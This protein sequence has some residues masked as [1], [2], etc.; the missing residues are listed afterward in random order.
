MG[1][2]S[3]YI[4]HHISVTGKFAQLTDGHKTTQ[5]RSSLMLLQ[6]Y[7]DPGEAFSCRTVTRDETWVFH[8]N[9]ESKVKLMTWMHL[10]SPGKKYTTVQSPEKVTATVFCNVYRVLL[11]D[12]TPH[13]PT[14][15]AAAY[16]GALK[17]LKEATQQNRQG[18]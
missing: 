6:H 11:V 16:Q 18:Q 14:V 10:H 3:T 15:N 8:D 13:G 4:H 7:G 1:S 5:M 12:F 2:V 17:R 9:P